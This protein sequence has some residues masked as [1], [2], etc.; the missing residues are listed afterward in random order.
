MTVERHP[1]SED[2]RTRFRWRL[3]PSL[4]FGFFGSFGL[5]GSLLI[6]GIAFYYNVRYGWVVPDPEY[7][8][9]SAIAI[10]PRNLAIW[11]CLCWASVAALVA[12]WAW[13]GGRWK[14]AWGATLLWLAAG[15]AFN[16]V[17]E[18]SSG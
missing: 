17:Q 15:G 3:I 1:V 7:P 10:T 12:S 5:L 9:L 14:V 2:R 6:S 11:Q 16:L 4:F 18:M 8:S 13:F